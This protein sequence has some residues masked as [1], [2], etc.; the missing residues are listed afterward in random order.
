MDTQPVPDDRREDRFQIV[1][2]GHCSDG[3]GRRSSAEIT[4]LSA[5]GCK[6]KT[7]PILLENDAFVWIKLGNRDPLRGQVRWHKG[8]LAGVRWEYP[9]HPAILDHIYAMHD[10]SR[11][12][13]P[14]IPATQR[15]ERRSP[16]RR[17]IKGTGA[18]GPSHSPH[19]SSATVIGQPS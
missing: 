13:L 7:T 3:A 6:V 4:E 9:L 2:R 1:L 10:A 5:H 19:Q 18:F 14:D 15:A 12:P 16:L 8:D 11:E 17:I